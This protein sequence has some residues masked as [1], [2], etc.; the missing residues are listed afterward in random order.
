MLYWVIILKQRGLPEAWS[1]SVYT[2]LILSMTLGGM[3]SRRLSRTADFRKV[4]TLST[5]AWAGLFFAISSS[6][7]LAVPTVLFVGVEVLYAI[8]S[9]AIATFENDIVS[10][11]NRAV[12]FSFMGT[13]TSIFGIAS[14][15][16][17]GRVADAWGVEPLY[18]FSG[19]LGL[20]AALCVFAAGKVRARVND[21]Y[22]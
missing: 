11:R 10:Q 12:V 9:A 1:G 16:L 17:I 4:A 7:G 19:F 6:R 2:M 14:N 13:V 5:L 8:R 21:K 18:Q 15:V 3:I 20:C 22:I